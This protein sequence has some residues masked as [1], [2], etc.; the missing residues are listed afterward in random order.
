MTQH[1]LRNI[2]CATS[3]TQAVWDG[4]SGWGG[5]VTD[6]GLGITVRTGRGCLSG[7]VAFHT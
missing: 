5:F 2:G 1:R 7:L 6:P 3:A 4:E